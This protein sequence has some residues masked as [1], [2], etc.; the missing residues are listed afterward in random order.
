MKKEILIKRYTL[1]ALLIVLILLGISIALITY[2]YYGVVAKGI[3][4]L[5]QLCLLYFF[6]RYTN[7]NVSMDTLLLDPKKG[8]YLI[9]AFVVPLISYWATAQIYEMILF[10][11]KR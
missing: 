6:G 9:S 10:F 5:I 2:R 8:K 11:W 1:S 4:G 7:M 3:L